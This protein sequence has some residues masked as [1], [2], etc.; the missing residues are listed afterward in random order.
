MVDRPE[1]E[2]IVFHM[3]APAVHDSGLGISLHDYF[4]AHCPITFT[5]FLLGWKRAKEAPMDEALGRFAELRHEYAD[6][7]L[8]ARKS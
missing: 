4:A 8:K 6:A 1:E 7:M 2:T 3:P 5:E